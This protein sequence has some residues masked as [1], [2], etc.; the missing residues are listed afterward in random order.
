MSGVTLGRKAQTGTQRHLA[1]TDNLRHNAAMQLF[2][3]NQKAKA[4]LRYG[5]TREQF[6]DVRWVVQAEAK[7]WRWVRRTIGR[8]FRAEERAHINATYGTYLDDAGWRKKT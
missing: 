4:N 7:A 8:P 1:A 3:A 5:L 2:W 6:A